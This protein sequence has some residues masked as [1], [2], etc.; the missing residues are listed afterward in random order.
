M[1]CPYQISLVHLCYKLLQHNMF[2][3]LGA[4]KVSYGNLSPNTLLECK[5]F[6][7]RSLVNEEYANHLR[8]TMELNIRSR[9][10]QIL[11]GGW[12]PISF[13]FPDFPYFSPMQDQYQPNLNW[14]FITIHNYIQLISRSR[15]RQPT[16][17]TKHI[18]CER[19]R[20][21][22]FLEKSLQKAITKFHGYFP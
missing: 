13:E 12:S 5:S 2:T 1:L 18:V 7:D 15:H 17:K 10:L 6:A 11:Q 16:F 20:R 22:R 4:T 19:R 14:Y 21:D 3:S 9:Q 8:S